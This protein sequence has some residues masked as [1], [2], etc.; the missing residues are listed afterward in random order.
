M[1]KVILH[2]DLNK[3]FVRCAEIKNPA[4]I[5]K[6]V[7]IGGDGRAGIVSTCSYEARKYG[8][9]SGMPMFKAKELCPNLIIEDIDSKFID[10]MS[11]EFINH[12]KKYTNIIEQI[13]CDECYCDITEATKNTN[14]DIISYLKEFQESLF[15]KTKLYCSIGV[16]PTKFLAKMG[17]DYKKP[18]GITIIRKRDIKTLL[19]PLPI[20]SFYGIGKKTNVKLNEIGIYKIG[21]L[22][23]AIKENREDVTEILGSYKNDII[24]DLEGKSSD[25][26]NDFS[27]LS[28]SIGTTSTLP[29]DSDEKPV[30]L[31]LY[32]KQIQEIVSKMKSENYLTKTI[33]LTIKDAQYDGKF[34][35]FTYSKT[36]DN[37]TDNLEKLTYAALKLFDESYKGEKIRLIGFSVKNLIHKS[38]IHTQMTF[39]DYK[40]HE[41]ESELEL[42]ISKLNRE[43]DKDLLKK[44][45]DIKKNGN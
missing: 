33:Q 37:L 18:S 6:P 7:A 42:L 34:K 12:V 15:N 13:S 19:F 40:I 14:F 21:E 30:I 31:K 43:F 27:P 35:T 23:Y 10:L 5:G 16:A 22:Y 2:I 36:I 29:Y 38:E 11:K 26:L 44:V 20:N 41:K 4:L 39:D 25:R 17:S 28:K 24:L 1:S 3:F 45:S 32:K 8:V 9:S